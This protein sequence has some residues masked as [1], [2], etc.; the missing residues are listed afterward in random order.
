MHYSIVSS[1]TNH[2]N[3]I[4]S[5]IMETIIKYYRVDRREISYIKFILEAYDNIAVLTTIDRDL[6]IVRI[7][8]ASGCEDVV[9][10]I[11]HDLKK[12]VMIKEFVDEDVEQVIA[13]W[14]VPK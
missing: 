3:G 1:K 4:K 9:E 11:L 7:S 14:L 6:G 13:R 2:R 10:M 5:I 8:V 12:D